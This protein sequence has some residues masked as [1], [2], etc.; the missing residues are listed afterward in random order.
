[1]SFLCEL[2]KH[3]ILQIPVFLHSGFAYTWHLIHSYSRIFKILCSKGAR[4]L[5]RTNEL[6]GGGVFKNELFWDELCA[7][8]TCQHWHKKKCIDQWNDYF[9]CT[10]IYTHWFE[11]HNLAY[12]FIIPINKNVA[13]I[14]Q[15]KYAWY[16]DFGLKK[17][18]KSF[19]KFCYRT[20]QLCIFN[21]WNTAKVNF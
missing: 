6:G 11:G 13:L 12:T 20:L 21:S 10:T 16:F 14:T 19:G 8:Y 18:G 17:I 4:S 5:S 2:S 3:I 1:M 7:Q 9:V 15:Y